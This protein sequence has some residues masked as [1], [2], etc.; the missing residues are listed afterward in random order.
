[1]WTDPADLS[2]Q[3]DVFFSRGFCP[4]DDEI[5][6]TRLSQPQRIAVV[7]RVHDSPLFGF[8]HAVKRACDFRVCINNE[9]EPHRDRLRSRWRGKVRKLCPRVP[10][11]K[12]NSRKLCVGTLSHFHLCGLRQLSVFRK[13]NRL[14]VSLL[15]VL[16][17]HI[18]PSFDEETA[19]TTSMAEWKSRD[20]LFSVSFDSYPAL[21]SWLNFRG[22]AHKR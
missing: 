2:Q 1:M 5:K 22:K 11:F 18:D 10:L 19:Q 9:C 17:L 16:W 12:F 13:R 14:V 20:S 6:G 3:F 15:T 21:S 4:S 7:G 8:K